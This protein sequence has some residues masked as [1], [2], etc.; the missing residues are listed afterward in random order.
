MRAPYRFWT[1]ACLA[2]SLIVDT[3]HSQALSSY[4]IAATDSPGSSTGAST[5]ALGRPDYKFANDLGLGF[6]GNSTDVFGPNESSVFQF[7]QPLKNIPGQADMKVSAF[8]GGQGATDSAMVQV[9]VS[10]DGV[11]FQVA[12]LFDTADGRTS[13]PFPQERAFES[14]KHFEVE[15]GPT[16]DVTHVRLTNLG[17]TS[18][19]L[20]LD[21]LEGFHPD[22]LSDHAFEI[23]FERVRG[24]CCER[25]IVRIKNLARANGVAIRE[26]RIDRPAGPGTTL[27]E[28]HRSLYGLSG[29]FMCVENCIPD[30]GPL[31]NFSRHA[32]SLDGITEAPPG[33]GLDPGRQ[34]THLRWW[35]FD[36]DTVGATFLSGYS[37]LV[38][39]TDNTSHTFTFDDDVIPL[40][41]EGMEYQK[42]QYFGS[43]P[44][45]SM[46]RR[47]HYY[48]FTDAGQVA[49]KQPYGAG[50]LGL[51]HDADTRPKTNTTIQLL[52][53]NMPAG[54]GLGATV[55][56]LT[57]INPGTDLTALG[58]T[59]CYQYLTVDLV[60]AWIPTAGV[61]QTAFPI[62]N[63]PNLSGFAF[64]TQGVVFHPGV[65]PADTLTSNGLLLTVGNF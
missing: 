39:F 10:N 9:E 40:N 11:N 15:F 41:E 46:P 36:L 56:S 26:F 1:M 35:N 3:A 65:N 14:V 21:A 24:S 28:T 38:T 54:A 2:A 59:G 60:E 29:E 19:G 30:N 64:V 16:D 5:V 12:A 53:D 62:P 55:M 33:V 63:N 47:V 51:S 42:Y 4:A 8:V 49:A 25:F 17:G 27:E 34:A 18:E 43:T 37:F 23:R 32:W 13:Y 61:G 6:G 31:I 52:T 7:A 57:Q 44:A 48:Q 50:C 22:L 20:R 58:L 45:E